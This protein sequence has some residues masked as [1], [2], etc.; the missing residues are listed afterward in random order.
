MTRLALA[1]AEAAG[2]KLDLKLHNLGL[3]RQNLE[4]PKFR[5]PVRDQIKVLNLVAEALEDDLLGFHLALDCEL[6]ETG[7]FYYILASSETL[8]DALRN[9]VRYTSVVNEGI[10]QKCFDRGHVGISM[11]YIGVSRYQDR[12]QLEFWMT[13]LL[14]MCRHLTG[15][16]VLPSLVQLAHVR[17]RNSPEMTKFF[18][19]PIQFGASGDELEF[20]A[21]TG[22]LPITSADPYLNKLLAAICEE[23][24]ANRPRIQN[25]FRLK[26]ENAVIP[27]LPHGRARVDEIARRLGISRR[28]FARRLALERLTFPKL[29]EQ[30]RVDLANRYFAHE[31]LS[32]SQIAWLLG[33]QDVGAFSHAFKRWTAKTP[34]EMRSQLAS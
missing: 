26:V 18:G 24:I 20:T 5:L 25:S 16:H 8:V 11:S 28:T 1:R 13:L 29:L 3:L 17:E 7:I 33:Y 2:L 15:H 12:H 10:N 34:R 32:I 23:A 6:R 9:A 14:R 4:N 21:T 27:L 22:Q 19:V 31:D 30:L